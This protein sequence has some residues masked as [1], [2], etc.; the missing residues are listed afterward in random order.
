MLV[1]Y[2]LIEFC[3]ALFGPQVGLL[4]K[5]GFSVES[6]DRILIEAFGR[7]VFCTGFVH[8]D[9]H[10]GNLF[11]RRRPQ[12]KPTN[13]V[14]FFT[15]IF[16]CL[17][18]LLHFWETPAQLVILDHGLYEGI[19]RHQRLALCSMYRAIFNNNEEDMKASAKLLNVNGEHDCYLNLPHAFE[20]WRSSPVGGGGGSQLPSLHLW[21]V[22]CLL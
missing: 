10:P 1:F 5:A 15:H 19:S 14:S 2:R 4:K 6:I 3:H 22:S 18:G 11:V 16:R 7:Q 9:P 8:A 21:A 17:A 13:S 12:P 20:G